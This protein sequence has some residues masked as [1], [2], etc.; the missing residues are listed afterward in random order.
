MACCPDWHLSCVAQN[1]VFEPATDCQTSQQFGLALHHLKDRSIWTSHC[2][3]PVWFGQGGCGR[4]CEKNL[5]A[6]RQTGPRS[7][8]ALATWA[9][10]AA[11]MATFSRLSSHLAETNIRDK[12]RTGTHLNIYKS[13]QNIAS[14]TQ[15]TF[16]R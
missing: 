6:F 5:Q 12:C 9:S 4:L 13:K 15:S 10:P 16:L 8:S 7:R 14:R 2:R 1:L 3:R 11:A